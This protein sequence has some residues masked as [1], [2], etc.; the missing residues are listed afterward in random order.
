MGKSIDIG[1]MRFG[2][3]TVLKQSDKSYVSPN[4]NRKVVWECVC[5]CGNELAVIGSNLRLGKSTNCGCVRD[6]AFH[7]ARRTHGDSR[8]NRLYRIYNDM[9][10]RCTCPSVTYFH[11]YGGRGISVCQEW[12]ESYEV[13]REWALANGYSDN[14]TID[15]INNDGNYEPSNCQWITASANS[16][17]QFVDRR[18][19]KEVS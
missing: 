11:R 5:D 14:L 9:K 15:R 1:G 10:T 12:K 3:L 17:K 13:F 7:A 2:M 4:G 19:V 6:I 8:G 16:K 18:L